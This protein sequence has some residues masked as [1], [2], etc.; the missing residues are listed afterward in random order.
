MDM[1]KCTTCD[2][3]Q[4]TEPAP[5]IECDDDNEDEEEENDIESHRF[6]RYFVD[7]CCTVRAVKQF[8]PHDWNECNKSS[9]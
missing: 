9:L 5:E 6:L 8:N 3:V 2:N 4:I 1:C 7:I